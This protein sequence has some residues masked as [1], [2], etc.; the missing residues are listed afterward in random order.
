MLWV[1]RRD[2]FEK[3]LRIRICGVRDALRRIWESG[4]RYLFFREHV[5][6]QYQEHVRYDCEA[7]TQNGA[8]GRRF[9]ARR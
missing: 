8:A 9:C 1:L 7:A 4:L 5:R 2:A 3:R 6:G